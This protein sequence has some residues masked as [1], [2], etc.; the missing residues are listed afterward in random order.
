MKR[1]AVVMSIMLLVLF[2]A[3]T[4]A[5]D[6]TPIASRDSDAFTHRNPAAD[7]DFTSYCNTH[8]AY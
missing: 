8:S 3:S 1:F 7:R 4:M 6:P 2:A 5:Q